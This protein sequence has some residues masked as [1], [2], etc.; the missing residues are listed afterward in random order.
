MF[1]SSTNPPASRDR[2]DVGC[3]TEESD[4]PILSNTASVPYV[5]PIPVSAEASTSTSKPVTH[6]KATQTIEITV[7]STVAPVAEATVATRTLPEAPIE[8]LDDTPAPEVSPASDLTLIPEESPVPEP[9][10]ARRKHMKTDAETGEE[11]ATLQ[12]HGLGEVTTKIDNHWMYVFFRFCAERHRMQE[13]RD[14]GVPRDQLSKDETMQKEHIGN[15]YREMDPGSKRMKEEI[16]ANGDQSH[17]EICCK[18][19]VNT[20][21]NVGSTLTLSLK[22][23]YSSSPDSMCRQHGKHSS[24]VSARYRT[25]RTMLATSRS[26][27][28]SCVTDPCVIDRSSIRRRSN[29]FPQQST[30]ARGY[31]ISRRLCGSSER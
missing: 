12:P 8:V 19:N 13:L 26:T 7:G 11:Y 22:S 20:F 14:I 24:T 15:I 28:R 25:G 27:K 3:N 4:R 21:N 30:S 1:L 16:I 17:E 10:A 5:A 2:E 6:D 23:A 18:L 29:S 31:L 9:P